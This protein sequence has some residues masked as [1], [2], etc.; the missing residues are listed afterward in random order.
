MA[1][2]ANNPSN[3]NNRRS[4]NNDNDSATGYS[5]QHA[6]A[7]V[8]S[9]FELAYVES[10]P[11]STPLDYAHS[12]AHTAHTAT[13]EPV[14]HVAL[15]RQGLQLGQRRPHRAECDYTPLAEPLSVIFP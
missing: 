14:H 5:K 8:D 9:P 11:D 13:V 4:N 6:V 10:Q 7:Y 3:S 12:N 2:Q 1:K 15:A